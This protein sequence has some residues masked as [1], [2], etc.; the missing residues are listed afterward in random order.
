MPQFPKLKTSQR[1]DVVVTGGGITGLT[2]AYLL[3]RAGKRVAVLERNRIGAVDTG[4]TSAHLTYVTDL[5]LGPLVKAFGKRAAQLVWQ[6]G[7]AAIN[8]IEQIASR[9]NIDCDFRRLPGFLHAPLEGSDDPRELQRESRLA[10]ELGFPAEFDSAVPLFDRPGIR[11]PDQARF[12]P[13]AYLA[14]LAEAIEG[15]GSAIFERSEVDRVTDERTVITVD[16]RRVESDYVVIATH[17]PLVGK[18]GVASAALLQS[19]LASYT[20]YVI[21]A[22]AKRGTVPE[23]LFWDTSDPY[24]YLR[25]DRQ[26]KYEYLIFGGEDHKTGQIA[27]SNRPFERL[28]YRLRQLAP[29]AKITDRW[30]GQV[31]ET[32]DGLPFIG[33]MTDGQFEAT[34][35]AGNGMTFGTLAAM[36]ACDAVNGRDNPW[37]ELFKIQRKKIRGGAWDY[38]KE[39]F[40]Y[41]YYLVRDRLA[42]TEGASTRS[43]R[44][45]EGKILRLDGQR[46]ACAR[47]EQ[48]K[49]TKVSAV[50]PH[51]GCLVR[52]NQSERNWDCPCH[53]SRFQATG[54][55]IAGPAESPLERVTRSKSKQTSR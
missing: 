25:V 9:E 29:G 6:G 1:F 14:G 7:V 44:P 49:L 38:L 48:G 11:F 30:S 35:F 28:E 32:N 22:R 21:G 33:E 40:D 15:D 4:N 51:M 16:Q 36:M 3:K 17:I 27:N 20:S 2:A 46:V 5:R 43:V 50:C 12:H 23:A 55:V 54:E 19:K 47:D 18:A 37:Q 52:W 42:A 13:L 41:P 39:N 8:T 26:E 31:I 24:D 45:G 53:G 10:V 34:G